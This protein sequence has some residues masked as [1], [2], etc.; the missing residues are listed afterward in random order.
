M[1]ASLSTFSKSEFAQKY[2][3]I[4]QLLEA[5]VV[6]FYRQHPEM[7]DSEVLCAYEAMLKDIKAELTNYPAPQHKLE[8][9]FGEIYG[10]LIKFLGEKGGSYS[11]LEIRECLKTLEKSL[12]MW[13]RERGSRGYLNFIGQFN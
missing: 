13:N 5:M 8:G 9:V 2:M 4:L 6:F 12:K 7:Y 10:E 1:N 11:I 3:G